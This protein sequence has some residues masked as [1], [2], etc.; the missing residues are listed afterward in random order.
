M[1]VEGALRQPRH[2][3]SGRSRARWTVL[4]P[5]LSVVLAALV[6]AR[7]LRS[8]PLAD[9]GALTAPAWAW[10]AGGPAPDP[11][12]SEG[13]AVVHTAAWG[14]LT[15][16]PERDVGLASAGRELL[17]ATLVLSCLLLWR[18]ARRARLGDA[19][20]AA[21]VL[22]FGAV[23]G[24]DL[25]HAVSSP[26]AWAVPWL[27]LAAWLGTGRRRPVVRVLGGL[28]V[29]PAVVLAPDVLLL[30][31]SGAAAA[32][33][34]GRLGRR[35]PATAR[36]VAAG[37]LAP[38]FVGLVL[39][40]PVWDPQPDV[41]APWSAGGGVPVLLTAGLLSAGVLAAWLLPRWRPPAA[42]LAVTTLAAVVPP[43]RFAALVVCLP[44]GAL[45]A[46]ALVQELVAVAAVRRLRPVLAGVAT[47][48]LVAALV[49]A[50]VL[51]RTGPTD[52]FGAGDRADLVAWLRSE[53]PRAR[54]CPPTA[55]WPR[56]CGRPGCRS[57]TAG[58]RWRADAPRPVP[59]AWWWPGSA[60]RRAA[61]SS[62]TRS[63]GARTPRSA[64]C[65]ASCRPPC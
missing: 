7:V 48:G 62:P 44:V 41:V 31:V 1:A 61:W 50:T 3:S 65:A 54:R 29:L 40:L 42:A 5:L 12:T 34:A 6:A 51:V 30:L 52:D 16:G 56:T 57:A 11:L 45:V 15:R 49:A 55:C 38:V 33:A 23:P 14:W 9:D 59:R 13:L 17:W 10:L 28:A 24:L 27:L 21:A 26:A 22:L 2:R 18:V 8:S 58:C 35:W 39:L 43:G 32:L 64:G 19:G 46:G 4:A 63:A 60:T 25:V 53:L 36:T 37:L 47:A 20:A